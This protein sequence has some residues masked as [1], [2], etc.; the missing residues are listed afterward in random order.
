MACTMASIPVAAV[1]WAGNPSVN[2]GS[3]IAISGNITGDTTPIF[4]LAPVVTI[5]M[6]VTSDPVPAVVGTRINGSLGPLALPTP[7][8][9]LSS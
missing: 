3:K 9:S 8:A 4:S 6:G 1:M 5:E 7:Y 2:S